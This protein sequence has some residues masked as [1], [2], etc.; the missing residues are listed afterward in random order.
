MYISNFLKHCEVVCS[1]KKLVLKYCFRLGLYK[2]GILHDM[3]KFTPS[4]MLV[5]IKYFQG[6]RSPNSAER[7]EKGYSA[8]WLHH[9][10]RNKHHF[11]YWVDYN[12]ERKDFEDRPLLI[13]SRMPV[14]YVLEMFTDRIAASRTYE[15]EAYTQE[16]PWKYHKKALDVYEV[17]HPDTIR[18]IERLLKLLAKEGEEVTFAYARYLLKQERKRN[19]KKL[20]FKLLGRGV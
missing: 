2:Q 14:K 5:G 17:M 12:G 20:C 7:E 10:G 19:F 8:S 13:G 6:N 4:E 9:K 11:E 1:H 16:S 3:S 18:L 15:R